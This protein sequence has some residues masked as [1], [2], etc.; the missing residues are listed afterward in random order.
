MTIDNKIRD[1]KLKYN[2]NTEAAKKIENKI[3]Y[4]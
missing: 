2:I 1:G 3:F 4:R